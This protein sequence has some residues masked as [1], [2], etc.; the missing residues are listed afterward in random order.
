VAA[1]IPTIAIPHHVPVPETIGAVQI[2]TLAG[3]EPQDLL[4]L[5]A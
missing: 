2:S 3:L 1:G 4:R 5:F